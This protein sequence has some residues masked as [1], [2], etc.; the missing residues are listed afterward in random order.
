[1]GVGIGGQPRGAGGC[2]A[3][4]AQPRHSSHT[5]PL[6]VAAE[7]GA[8]GPRALLLAV[9]RGVR[10]IASVHRGDPALGLALG[11]S[12]LAL[13]V[14]ALSY[15]GFL[16]DPL[17]W[18][19]LGIA[20]A[21]ASGM[22]EPAAAER[23]A[24][25]GA[26]AR[27]RPAGRPG[28]R[29]GGWRGG[30]MSGRLRG[31][32]AG[33]RPAATGAAGEIAAGERAGA[34]AHRGAPRERSRTPASGRSSGSCWR[35]WRSPG[36]ARL[37]PLALS[38]R[39]RGP[40]G[41]AGA[42]CAGGRRGVDGHRAGRRVYG[43]APLWRR[44][45]DPPAG[46]PVSP[47]VALVLAVGLLLAAPSTLLQLGLRDS[48]AAPWFHTNDS[49]YQIELGGELVL[50]GEN[51]YGHDYRRSG[52]ERF[53]TRD[54][55]V[56]E[57]VREREVALEHFAYFP[58]SLPLAAPWRPS[59]SR[60]PT[61]A[62]WSCS[63]RWPGFAAALAFRAPPAWRLWIG[64]LLATS[65]SR[66]APRGSARTTLPACC[67]RA[68][69][70]ARHTTPVRLAAASLAAAVL[71]QF[72]LVALPFLAL[73]LVHAGAARTE[74]SAA[75]VF[76]AV[77]AAGILPFLAADPVAFYETRCATGRG[78]TASS[79]TGSAILLRLGGSPIA[80]A[81]TPLA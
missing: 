65:R 35:S 52:L 36:R 50:D 47:G 57:R 43:G 5:T 11:A 25:A 37:E 51:P 9:A 75:L 49:T 22:R 42:A 67:C 56:S 13:F 31:T 7:L 12:F 10:L 62:C 54:G 58:G 27:R 63:A 64:A 21:F 6:T 3:A 24:R 78:P 77:V 17:T 20:A 32:L 26:R 66:S 79:A 69:V 2:R 41:T 73:M 68:R 15:S 38:P 76:G 18:L 34:R 44:G 53:Y 16:E 40:A 48:N 70:R 60:S 28:A 59:P 55:H 39:G 72:A 74:L 29:P 46:D 14:H 19:V 71:L 61:T 23:F 45:A 1:M 30:R 33:G 80:R 8:I 4:T 81:P